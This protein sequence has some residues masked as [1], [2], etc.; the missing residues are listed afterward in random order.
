M[1]LFAHVSC[2]IARA[3]LGVFIGALKDRYLR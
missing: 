3:K 1:G 2:V